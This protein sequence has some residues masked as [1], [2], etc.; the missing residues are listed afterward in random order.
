MKNDEYYKI[1]NHY[2]QC[3]IKN[4]DNHLGVD[5][6]NEC[7][8]E[9]RYGVM[10]DVIRYDSTPDIEKTNILD[11]GCG[12]GHLYNYI[13]NHGINVRYTGLDVSE[14]FVKK[15]S[16]KYPEVNFICSDILKADLK[17][18]YGYIIMNG[19]F[20]EK[21]EL[22]YENM[23]IY[24]M[25]VITKV[26]D[27]CERG[28]AFNVMSKDVDWEREDL[29]HVPLNEL[30]AFLTKNISRNFVIRNDYGL[31]EYTTYVYR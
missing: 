25:N 31:Y 9:K 28:I 1:I 29:F 14:I 2:E 11:F 26:F 15:C 18:K 12:L 21:R 7:D 20:T 6:P 13:Q 4:G 27:H 8:A 19:V 17:G 22:S 3:Y 30:S 23:K 16:E 24:F 5:W 10:L